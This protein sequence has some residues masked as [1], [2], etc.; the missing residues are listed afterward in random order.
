MTI[1][2]TGTVKHRS[3]HSF[4]FLSINQSINQS[5]RL[6]QTAKIHR[7]ETTEETIYTNNIWITTYGIGRGIIF[8]GQKPAGQPRKLHRTTY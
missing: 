8:S 5:R 3:V 6:I 4:A 7:T 1:C 2:V